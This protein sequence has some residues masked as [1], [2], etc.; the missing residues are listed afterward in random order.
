MPLLLDCLKGGAATV[1]LFL[2]Y[3]SLPV[4]GLVLGVFTPYPAAYYALSRGRAAGIAISAMSA[5]AIWAAAGPANVAIYF[6]F[7]GIISLLLPEFLARGKGAARSLGYTLVVNV[8]VVALLV[9]VIGL[10]KGIDVNALVVKGIQASIEQSAKIYEKSGLTG[11]DL[12]QFQD[13]LREAGGLI[14]RIYPALMVVALGT[15][16]GC[17][18]LLLKRRAAKFPVRLEFGRF[19][20]FKNPDHLIWVLIAAGF[21]LLVITAWSSRLR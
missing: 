12:K 7:F 17:N 2:A 14:S 15:I 1:L 3:L 10:L 4:I 8:V 11:D 21:S 20:S 19:S 6:C 18:L 9:A 16:A 5:A 13:A